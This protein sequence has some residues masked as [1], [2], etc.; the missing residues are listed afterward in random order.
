M[1]RTRVR[2]GRGVRDR[3]ERPVGAI[4]GAATA[5]TKKKMRIPRPSTAAR[6]W[7]T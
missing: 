4:Q 3:F 2:E 6:L 5:R 7:S 1:L